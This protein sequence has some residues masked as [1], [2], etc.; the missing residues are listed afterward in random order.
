MV[1]YY[2][3]TDGSGQWELLTSASDPRIPPG[4]TNAATA[5]TDTLTPD[6]PVNHLI[7]N[8]LAEV[9]KSGHFLWRLDWSKLRADG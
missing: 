9:Q 5:A 8:G 3:F 4:L 2:L 1:Q 7:S 6:G